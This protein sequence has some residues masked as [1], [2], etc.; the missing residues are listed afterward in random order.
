M[1]VTAIDVGEIVTR[2]E[3]EAAAWDRDGLPREMVELA[4]K[5][6]VLGADRAAGPGIG[7]HE[8]GELAATL[9]A[10][11]SSTR[12]LLTV[13]GMVAAAVDRWGTAR[14]REYW[15]PR[16][17]SGATLPG[18]AV[19]EDGAGTELAAV[20]TSLR[21][22]GDGV[23]VTG[24][25]LWVSF[26]ELADVLLV[27]ARAEKGPVAVLVPTDRPGVRVEPVADPLGLRGARLAHIDLD[28]VAVPAENV[29]APPGFGLS[30]VV[31]T[32]LDHGR[33]TVAWGCVGMARACLA[34][35]AQRAARRRP[36]GSALA[37]HQ[38]VRAALGRCWVAV[39][40]AEALCRRAAD[41]RAGGDAGAVRATVAAKYA[42]A[43]AA[44]RVAREA[45]QLLGAAGCGPDSRAGRFYRDAKVME[46]IEGPAAVAELHLGDHVLT[47]AKAGAAQ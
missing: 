18:L 4:A 13:A 7:A 46:I 17:V 5:C 8:L 41:L 33:F 38:L 11:C 36:D 22:D 26:G 9:G 24:R 16:F 44:A 32:A 10:V 1:S 39:E 45:V 2:A 37:D 43:A 12:S 30:H 3:A 34:E 14:Q 31:G 27:L 21:P 40:G 35:A 29:L 28:A 15:L 20:R 19:T 25:K 42:A 6:G 47:T 23:V